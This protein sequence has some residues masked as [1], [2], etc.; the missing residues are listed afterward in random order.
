[1]MPPGAFAGQ[2]AMHALISFEHIAPRQAVHDAWS[3]PLN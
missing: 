1:M 3:G 2:F